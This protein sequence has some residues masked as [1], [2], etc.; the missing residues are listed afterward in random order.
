MTPTERATLVHTIVSKFRDQQDAVVC[1]AASL[2][3]GHVMQL[4]AMEL[5]YQIEPEV[6]TALADSPA[7]LS[8]RLLTALFGAWPIDAGR[9]AHGITQRRQGVV[10]SEVAWAAWESAAQVWDSGSLPL[11]RQS[12]SSGT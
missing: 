11:L 10:V 9:R 4:N 8:E 1:H 6:F 2:A 7:Q 5:T 3:A 12:Q